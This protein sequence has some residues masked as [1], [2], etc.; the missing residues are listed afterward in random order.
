MADG[1]KPVGQRLDELDLAVNDLRERATGANSD[2]VL[3]SLLG[4]DALKLEIEEASDK[5]IKRRLTVAHSIMVVAAGVLGGTFGWLLSW[6]RAVD[7]RESA[8][9]ALVRDTEHEVRLHEAIDLA[10]RDFEGR[11]RGARDRANAAADAASEARGQARQAQTHASHFLNSARELLDEA[12]DANAVIS[13]LQEAQAGVVAAVK[14]DPAFKRGVIEEVR[15]AL[16][17]VRVGTICAWPGEIPLLDDAWHDHWAPCDGRAVSF[18]EELWSVL[19]G[20]YDN[21]SK[22]ET[23]LLPNFKGVFLRGVG[24]NSGALGDEQKDAFQEHNHLMFRERMDG[25]RPERL[26]ATTTP[27]RQGN[28]ETHPYSIVRMQNP[29]AWVG[30][31]GNNGTAAETRPINSAVHWIIRVK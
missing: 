9:A 10:I 24:G 17:R 20:R 15:S 23:I 30:V 18:N 21:R 4:S 13:S 3:R 12:T 27:S 1:D 25:D 14:E 16:E 5:H 6:S 28:H 7:V 22:G 26:T 2:Q 8:A 29:G 11:F 31:T 19:G